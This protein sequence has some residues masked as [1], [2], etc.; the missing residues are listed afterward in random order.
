[1]TTSAARITRR[2]GLRTLAPRVVRQ[3]RMPYLEFSGVGGE[4]E[5]RPRRRGTRL[6][7]DAP[8][9]CSDRR[10]TLWRPARVH[11]AGALAARDLTSAEICEIGLAHAPK[12]MGVRSPRAVLTATCVS[13]LGIR[14]WGIVVGDRGE[15]FVVGIFVLGAVWWLGGLLWF[16][17]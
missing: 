5:R 12:T 17:Y 6:V 8:R 10:D 3:R 14:G 13:R 9:A 4:S 7:R 16:F 11:Q 15:C 1:M 2:K